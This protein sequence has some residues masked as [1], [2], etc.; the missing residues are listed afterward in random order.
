M[1]IYAIK[2]ISYN[3]YII[4]KE[5]YGKVVAGIHDRVVSYLEEQ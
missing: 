2:N 3:E 5:V 1:W 4:N